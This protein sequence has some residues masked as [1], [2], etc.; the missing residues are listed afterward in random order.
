MRLQ[1]LFRSSGEEPWHRARG[2]RSH[3][4]TT[5]VPVSAPGTRVLIIWH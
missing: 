5:R 3:G 4:F 2:E 1:I